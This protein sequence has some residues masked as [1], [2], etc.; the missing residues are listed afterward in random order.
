MGDRLFRPRF[1]LLSLTGALAVALCS[2]ALAS[3]D[4]VSCSYL[5]GGS[6]LPSLVNVQISPTG[7]FATSIGR[8]GPG[9]NE[10]LA[11]G[12]NSADCGPA[13]VNNTDL[14]AMGD[15]SPKSAGTVLL[16][17]IPV[18]STAVFEPGQTPEPGNSDEIEMGV[19][20]GPGTDAI[21]LDALHGDGAPVTIRMGQGDHAYINLNAAEADGIDQDVSMEGVDRITFDSVSK[22]GNDDVIR[23]DGGAG[24]GPAPI[25]IRV[26]LYGGDGDD[27]LTGGARADA[28]VGGKGRDL[29]AAGA[30][31]DL[32]DGGR[33]RDLIS[34]GRTRDDLMGGGGRDLIRGQKGKDNI[35][36]GAGSDRLV[37][38]PGTDTCNGGPGHD[39]LIGC[40]V[41]TG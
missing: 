38:G 18:G 31:R 24:T 8:G 22:Q 34:G 30:G 20:F 21:G 28:L 5:P 27:V 16:H 11:F 39:V 17:Y 25:K 32:I 4:S 40:E 33:A 23:A 35:R 6:L 3:A 2:P 1:W 12:D 7:N 41:I 9:G 37:G 29:L 26:F 10:I 15:A 13:T 19:S 36:G 14:I